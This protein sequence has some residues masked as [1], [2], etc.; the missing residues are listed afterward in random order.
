MGII[1]QGHVIFQKFKWIKLLKSVK[2]EKE[3]E[4]EWV[5]KREGREKKAG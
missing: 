3:G 2:R 5:R 4:K 1:L